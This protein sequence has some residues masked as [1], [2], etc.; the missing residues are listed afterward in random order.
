MRDQ[1]AVRCDSDATCAKALGSR[2]IHDPCP[3]LASK[4]LECL[5]NILA[6]AACLGKYIDSRKQTRM[7]AVSPG[8]A[9]AKVTFQQL[10]LAD[11][12]DSTSVE[13]D[14]ELPLTSIAIGF[15]LLFNYH[16]Q[17]YIRDAT[18]R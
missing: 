12:Q 15:E 3:V 2:F 11:E 17:H 5:D 16:F 9:N 8:G 18:Q 14:H 6:R 1:I 7:E 4:S 13:R 10:P